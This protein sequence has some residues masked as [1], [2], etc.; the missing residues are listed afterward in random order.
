[1]AAGTKFS[2][3][4]KATCDKKCTGTAK[5]LDLVGDSG[6][7]YTFDMKSVKGKVTLSKGSVE[8]GKFFWTCISVSL[9]NDK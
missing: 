6:N 2:P 3:K 8:L 5:R 4:S 1:M 9:N 7:V